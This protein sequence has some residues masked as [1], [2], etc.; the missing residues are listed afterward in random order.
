MGTVVQ[1]LVGGAL[2]PDPLGRLRRRVAATH[3]LDFNRTFDSLVFVAGTGRSGT[4]WLV[5]LLNADRRYRV[6]FEPFRA[7]WGVVGERRLPRYIRPLNDDPELIE[8]VRRILLARFPSNQ[9]T[10]RGSER[11]FSK[12]RIIKDVDSNLRLAWFRAQFPRFP[13]VLIVRHPCGVAA[14]RARLGDLTTLN[15]FLTDRDLLEDHLAPY[16]KRLRSLETPFEIEVARW[17]V[18]TYVP[19]RQA[20]AGLDIEVVLYERLVADP[21]GTVAR[22]LDRLGLPAPRGL[23]HRVGVPSLT[24]YRED[25]PLESA[26]L[27]ADEWTRRLAEDEIARAVELIELFGLDWLYGPDAMPRVASIPATPFPAAG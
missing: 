8:T 7:K 9:W 21:E 15:A 4:T 5:D 2:K 11:I 3:P 17:C 18:E 24:A 25:E 12:R 26:A 20:S 16:A 19:L 1:K 10:A 22:L 13:V 23:A 6:I 27:A 14:S